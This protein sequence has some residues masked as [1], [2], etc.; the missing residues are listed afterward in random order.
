M[1][2]MI[3]GILILLL[4]VVSAALLIYCLLSFVAPGS[5]LMEFLRPHMEGILYP[6]RRLLF[7]WFPALMNSPMDFSPLAVWLV[8]DILMQLLRM[9]QRAL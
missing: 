3:F 1:F 4:R 2:S 8:I 6:F 5:R 7:K 9:L